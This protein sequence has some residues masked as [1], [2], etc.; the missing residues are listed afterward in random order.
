MLQTKNAPLDP[1]SGSF[2]QCEECRLSHQWQTGMFPWSDVLEMTHQTHKPLFVSSVYSSVSTLMHLVNTS[3]NLW[4]ETWR[5]RLQFLQ[6]PP[7]AGPVDSQRYSV[8]RLAL[9]SMNS[10][11]ILLNVIHNDGVPGRFL[12]V[13]PHLCYSSHWTGLLH[14]ISVFGTFFIYLYE[15]IWHVQVCALALMSEFP[16]FYYT[17]AYG[18]ANNYLYGW[19]TSQSLNHNSALH[20]LVQVWPLFPHK[21]DT[22]AVKVLMSSKF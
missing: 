3:R 14:H 20:P 1:D 8:K 11:W 17:A 15:S 16:V 10:S 13:R 21:T 9:L 19:H 5:W 12:S 22:V 18:P 4:A 2:A 6:W 7:E